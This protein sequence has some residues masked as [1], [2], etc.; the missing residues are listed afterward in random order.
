MEEQRAKPILRKITNEEREP[1][2]A[3]RQPFKKQE[4]KRKENKRARSFA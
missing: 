2:K 4:K 3:F 1:L